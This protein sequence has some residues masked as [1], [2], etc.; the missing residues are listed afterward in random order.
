MI[1]KTIHLGICSVALLAAT[2]VGGCGYRPV[3]MRGPVAE[4]NGVHVTLFA[5]RTY[6]PGV[7][8]ILA[9]DLVDR[10]ALRTGGR[11]LPGDQAQL[12]LTGVVVSYAT[13]PIS[14]T[15]LDTIKEYKTVIGVQATLLET[16]THK[17]LWKGD[18]VGEQSFPVNQNI[19]LQQ[20]A[21][22]A[23]TAKVCRRLSEEIWQKIGER[24]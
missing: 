21:E 6:R 17:V 4:A 7:E 15:A 18:L 11:V 10:F 2:V 13:L 8:G 20:N 12:E 14:F 23:A 3:A 22:Q 1:A 9:R 16:K 5:N 19:A 24:F